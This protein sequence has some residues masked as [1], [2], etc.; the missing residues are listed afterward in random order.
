M[1]RMHKWA[2][3]YLFGMKIGM[4]SLFKILAK[5]LDDLD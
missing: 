3:V 5:L 2:S 4:Q 1:L